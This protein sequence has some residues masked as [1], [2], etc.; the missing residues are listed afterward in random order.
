VKREP[1][2]SWRKSDIYFDL[3]YVNMSLHHST[4]AMEM[5]GERPALLK[6]LAM[7]NV[8][9]GNV[10]SG[11]IYL[12]CLSQIPFQSG[13]AKEYLAKMDVDPSLTSDPEIQHLRECMARNDV[14]G[15]G[16]VDKEMMLLLFANRNNRMAFEY[17]ITYYLLTR[18]LENF[19]QQLPRINDFPDMKLSPL[20]QEAL[21]MALYNATPQGDDPRITPEVRNRFKEVMKIVKESGKDR[22]LALARMELKYANTYFY[23]YLFHE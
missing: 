21:L 9:I 12:K 14:V 15:H 6:R 17:M 22:T 10:S 1:P 7:I 11:K 3:G 16:P 19:R 20:W 4:E 23:Y 18:D 13:W 2:S 8:A 5:F